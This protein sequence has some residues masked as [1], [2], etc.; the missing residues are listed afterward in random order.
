MDEHTIGVC[1]TSAVQLGYIVLYYGPNSEKIIGRES[2]TNRIRV[3]I[4]G[5][6]NIQIGRAHV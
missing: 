6:I 4:F 1:D 5:A 2:C 3:F